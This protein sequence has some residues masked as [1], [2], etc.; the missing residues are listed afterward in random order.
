MG[1]TCTCARCGKDF[2]SEWSDEDALAEAQANFSP[3]E[4]ADT[5]VV[6]D[7][8]YELLIEASC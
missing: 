1:E 5:A 6:C 7:D 2:V 4:L 3:E 8:C